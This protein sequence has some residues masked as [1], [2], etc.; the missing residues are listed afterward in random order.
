MKYSLLTLSFSVACSGLGYSAIYS[1]AVYSND[2]N[3]PADFPGG[4]IAGN[5]GWLIAGADLATSP[6]ASRIITQFFE[7]GVRAAA[8][9]WQDINPGASSVYLYQTINSQLVGNP[10][11][12]T[13][14]DVMAAIQ[15]SSSTF[16]GGNILRDT[17]GFTFRDKSDRNIFT[18][19]FTPLDPTPS[20]PDALPLRVDETSWSSDFATGRAVGTLT[21]NQYITLDI[22]FTKGIGE[23]VNFTV[24]DSGGVLASG[25]LTG[26]GANPILDTFGAIWTPLAPDV[27]GS[28]T[29][30]NSLM[31]DTISLI[32]EPA[33]A[34]LGLLG[35]S[36]VFVRRRRACGI[37]SGFCFSLT[38]RSHPGSGFFYA[39]LENSDRPTGP[40]F[41]QSLHERARR[42]QASFFVREAGGAAASQPGG[43]AVGSFSEPAARAAVLDHLGLPGVLLVV[44]GDR[45]AGQ[46]ADRDPLRAGRQLC[47]NQEPQVLSRVL[48]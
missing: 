7:G 6:K 41:P 25:T 27:N 31:F 21:E 42:R 33:S 35:V 3:T 19:T 48:P 36:F 15:D 11:S 26:L 37:S 10:L 32:P 23:D 29:G 40:G 12:Y 46:R 47:G 18:F 2:F 39:V 8:L 24:T 20:D 34:L 13:K 4:N 38:G 30:S 16:E 17:F 14:F 1:N 5:D 9:G 43:G 28:N 45:A 44:S 22:T